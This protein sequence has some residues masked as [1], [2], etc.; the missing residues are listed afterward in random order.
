MPAALSQPAAVLRS[1]SVPSLRVDAGHSTADI[2][3][4]S[5]DRGAIH[6][7]PSDVAR[8][9]LACHYAPLAAPR[10]VC[11]RCRACPLPAPNPI[12]VRSAALSG[13]ARGP[14]DAHASIFLYVSL[15]QSTCH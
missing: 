8:R 4:G 6:D 5:I 7:T 10:D 2:Q 14:H 1:S 9:S 15:A 11:A 12:A 3:T 13:L